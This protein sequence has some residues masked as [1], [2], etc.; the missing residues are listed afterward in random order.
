ME[1]QLAQL[2]SLR[3]RTH[4]AHLCFRSSRISES[5]QTPDVFP[6]HQ[7]PKIPQALCSNKEASKDKLGTLTLDPQHRGMSSGVMQPLLQFSTLN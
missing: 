3:S 4:T 6:K 7:L 5:P 1:R 2:A